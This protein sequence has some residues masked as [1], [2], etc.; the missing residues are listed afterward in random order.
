VKREDFWEV[1][2]KGI[3]ALPKQIADVLDNVEIMVRNRP[4]R[5]TRENIEKDGLLLG[6]YVGTPITR[7]GDGYGSGFYSFAP[8]DRIY[9]FQKNI[10]KYCR[11]TG[12][13]MVHQIKDTLF[14]EIG[15][16]M[17]L[18]EEEVR[19]LKFKLMI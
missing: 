6:L 13:S 2:E 8:P 11:I 12:D 18:N 7:R 3:K 5:E 1:V 14:H 19:K 16:Y 10:E 4:D 17:G 15:H 9:L